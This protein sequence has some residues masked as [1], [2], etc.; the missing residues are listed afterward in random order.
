MSWL[1]F[2]KLLNKRRREEREKERKK[3]GRA[4]QGPD[5]LA[6]NLDLGEKLEPQQLDECKKK[7]KKKKKKKVMMIEIKFYTFSKFFDKEK[8]RL[9]LLL[10]FFKPFLLSFN[11]LSQEDV[12][13]S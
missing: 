6:G 2:R 8:N 7:K 13:S 3:G 1:G 9:L 11:V 4:P 12:S 10:R 5:I